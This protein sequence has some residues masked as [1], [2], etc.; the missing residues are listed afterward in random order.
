[1]HRPSSKGAKP[2]F[3]VIKVINIIYLRALSRKIWVFRS[4]T[5]LLNWGVDFTI[6]LWLA[7]CKGFKSL[8][9]HF[10]LVCNLCWSEDFF[11][12]WTTFYKAN[13]LEGNLLRVSSNIG[14]NREI[15]P[16]W[17]QLI[18]TRSDED[19]PKIWCAGLAF[20]VSFSKRAVQIFERNLGWLK[21]ALGGLWIHSTGTGN[22]NV[23][24][25]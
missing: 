20:H 24:C 2:L 6:S 12:N 8:K 4:S 19:N 13:S 15:S 1:V 7:L 11:L 18:W 23:N 3:I 16:K 25:V 21:I 17:I 10:W 9:N 5:A 22:S 14:V